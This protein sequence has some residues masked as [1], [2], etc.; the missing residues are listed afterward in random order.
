MVKDGGN[1][2]VCMVSRVWCENSSVSGWRSASL[3]EVSFSEWFG[4]GF[5]R[6]NNDIRVEALSAVMRVI[7]D[8]G[9]ANRPGSNFHNQRTQ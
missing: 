1:W 4:V 7:P 6:C 5:G 3:I 8:G 9:L 2:S